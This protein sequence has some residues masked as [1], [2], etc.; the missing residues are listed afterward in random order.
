MIHEEFHFAKEKGYG[1]EKQ[2]RSYLQESVY[3]RL[4]SNNTFPSE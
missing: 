4:K 2:M 3:I 1:K